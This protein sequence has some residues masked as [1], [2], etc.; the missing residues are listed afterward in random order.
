[1][2][3]FRQDLRYALRGFLQRP[4]YTAVLVFTLALGIG[5]NVAIFS[6]VNAVLFQPL[7]FAEPE[8]LVLVWNRL[9][10]SNVDRALVSGPDFIDYQQQ[11]TLFEDFA[12]AA[13][14]PGTLTGE[15]RAEQVLVAWTT[16]N[17]QQVLGVAPMIG[18][19]FEEADAPPIDPAS[20]GDPNA[21]FP[22]GA[23]ILSYG[24]WQRRFGSDS[25]VLGMKLQVDGQECIIVGVMP[26]DFRWYLPPDAGMPT[27]IDVWRAAPENMTTFADR[28]VAFFTVLGRLKDG[29]TLAQGQA[30]MDRLATTLREQYQFHAL[31]GMHITV[32]SMHEDIV[33]HVRPLLLAVVAAAGFVLLIACA[34]VANLLLVRAAGREREIAV[35][36]AL[37]GGRGRI[38]RQMLTESGVFS[39]AGGALGLL[40]AW[41][42]NRALLTMRPE[43]LP[44]LETVG[45][46]G[47]VLAFT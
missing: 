8:Q 44:R 3:D 28:S 18:R 33:A 45:I 27:D 14:L 26:R 2:N 46:D 16:V 12:G 13:A 30:E 22:P 36:A 4:G 47:S 23:L 6:V 19:Y 39:I 38:I 24:L 43:N 17:F 21:T 7:P 41:W 37:G 10:N 9:E 29:V 1:M 20:F 15:G 32:N 25:N 34:N 42:G 31:S 5:S 35:R 11:T 40:M